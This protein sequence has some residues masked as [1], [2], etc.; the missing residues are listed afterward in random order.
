M[1]NWWRRWRLERER[2]DRKAIDLIERH[3]DQAV[4]VARQ[5]MADAMQAGDI[6]ENTRWTRIRKRIRKLTGG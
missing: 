4:Y 1:I 2:I 6:A 5:R 3:G